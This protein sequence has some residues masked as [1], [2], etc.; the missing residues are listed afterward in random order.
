M[1][2]PFR[3]L[4]LVAGTAWGCGCEPNL[5]HEPS[6]TA[7]LAVR[8]PD[9]IAPAGENESADI[10]QLYAKREMFDELEP[11]TWEL[12]FQ[13]K[14][15]GVA[16]LILAAHDRIEDLDLV[17]TP[18]A[19]WGL[20]D[21]RQFGARP[22]F[23]PDGGE[24]FLQA[25]RTALHRV[26]ASASWKSS[27]MPPGVQETVRTGTEPAWI[28]FGEGIDAVVIR[29]VMRDRSARIDY[30]GFFVEPPEGSIRVAGRPAIPP[31]VPPPRRT[32]ELATTEAIVEQPDDALDEQL[33]EA[34]E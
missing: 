32:G 31:T 23:G 11:R 34:V 16:L 12:P 9:P 21:R 28:S 22:V 15:L 2:V 33:D 17:L 3:R 19:R 7:Q 10:L 20:P 27:P 29:E 25:F 8:V 26:P 30:I 24:A 5:P 6:S 14:R 18:D 13:S 1:N 4:A